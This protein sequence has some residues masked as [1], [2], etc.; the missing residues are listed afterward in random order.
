MKALAM[1]LAGVIACVGAAWQPCAGHAAEEDT[2]L[3]VYAIAQTDVS[4]DWR[5]TADASQRWRE[6]ARGGD[7]YT[8]RATLDTEAAEGV[9]VGGGL[10]I[11]ETEFGET[12]LRPHQQAEF[13]TGRWSARTRIEQRFFDGADRMELRLRQRIRFTQPL[14]PRWQASA[15]GEYFHLAQRRDRGSQAA[16]DQWRGRVMLA[17]DFDAGW[18]ASAAYLVIY[19]PHPVRRDS[20]N[21][22][23]QV[24]VT[25]S[26]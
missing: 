8:L 26:F 22:V 2:Q 10:G 9:R 18:S 13:N 14:G 20:V 11:F 3:W 16:R 15:D 4:E 23:P 17:R 24:I 19:N 5:L 7:Q 25:R 6:N 1:R 21:H 12:E